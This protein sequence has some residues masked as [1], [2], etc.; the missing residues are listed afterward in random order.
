M[1]IGVR[2]V[3]GRGIVL[4]RVSFVVR[5]HG[6]AL[7]RRPVAYPH[8]LLFD[9][10]RYKGGIAEL[11]A[12]PVRE[13]VVNH[14]NHIHALEEGV[15]VLGEPLSLGDSPAPFPDRQVPDSV[16]FPWR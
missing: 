9:D 7:L 16:E 11:G 13:L 6:C 3:L 15:D 10:I 5:H 1:P 2:D 12:L 8:A 4:R 14:V